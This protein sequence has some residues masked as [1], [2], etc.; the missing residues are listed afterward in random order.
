MDAL[1][2]PFD[3]RPLEHEGYLLENWQVFS[4]TK[5]QAVLETSLGLIQGNHSST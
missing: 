3:Q 2:D 4:R 1:Y 5:K